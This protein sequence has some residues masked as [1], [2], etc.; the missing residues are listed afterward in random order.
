MRRF[1]PKIDWDDDEV[2]D[3][4]IFESYQMDLETEFQQKRSQRKK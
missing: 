1:M 3:M 4:I 2:C